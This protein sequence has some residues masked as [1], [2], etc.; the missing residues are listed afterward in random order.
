VFPVL[1]AWAKGSTN[2]DRSKKTSLP[3]AAVI[4]EMVLLNTPPSKFSAG[5][6]GIAALPGR[7]FFAKIGHFQLA[8]VPDRSE[9]N[10]GEVNFPREVIF[11]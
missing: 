11:T 8:G 2:L 7:E 6:R 3:A 4:L 10:V 1:K 9:P 5:E